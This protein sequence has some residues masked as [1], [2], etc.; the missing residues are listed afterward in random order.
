M[1][2][3]AKLVGIVVIG[4]IVLGASAAFATSTT[5]SNLEG[6]H[7]EKIAS[8]VKN[9]VIEEDFSGSVLVVKKGK[10]ILNQSFGL[11]DRESKIPFSND[12]LFQ[13]GSMAKSMIAIAILKLEEEGKISVHD[14]LS[15][16]FQD[17]PNSNKITIHEMLNHSSGLVDFLETKE[18]RKNYS[19]EHSEEQILNSF[20]NEPLSFEPGEEFAYTNSAYY[21][22]GKIIEEVSGE[23]Y[24]SFIE[25]NIFKKAGMDETHIMTKESLKN[26]KVKGYENGKKA[27]QIDPALLFAS[28]NVLSTKM[29]MA[30][31]LEAIDTDTLI[32]PQ[33][34]E[35][36]LSP[37][38]KVNPF[39]IGYG[40]GW[41]TGNGLMSFN[42][43]FQ[44]HGGSLPGLRVG[45]SHFPEKE[46]SIII[47]NN[48]GSE[49][50]YAELSNG[51]ASILLNKRQWF[52]HKL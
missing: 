19:E 33:Q 51:I 21:L 37:T 31:Y 46:I 5:H 49:W 26:V 40:Y 29:D 11:A 32:S 13:V 43:K 4:L 35:K 1:K 28:G 10:V 38:I 7:E 41:Y 48:T 23:E 8:Y 27:E 34:K 42:E 25:K 17:I 50:N 39:G 15:K 22:L 16:Y 44:G 2:K 30:K 36:M 52:I 24:A 45:I 12:M 14:K 20:K 18:I 47:F 6:S 9:Y 3:F